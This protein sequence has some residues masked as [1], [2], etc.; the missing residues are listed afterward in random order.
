MPYRGFISRFTVI[1]TVVSMAT[2]LQ[3]AGLPDALAACRANASDAERLACYDRLADR[4]TGPDPAEVSM[5]PPDPVAPPAG[6]DADV[7]RTLSPEELFGLSAESIQQSLEE[8]SGNSP[9]SELSALVTEVKP[10]GPGRILVMLDN[11]QVWHQVSSPTLRLK[12]RDKVTIRKAAF[13]SY[14]MNKEG[15]SRTMRVRRK[16]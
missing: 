7:T 2:A 16:K 8:T 14:K 13:G 9:I 5:E 6:E 12:V 1:A 15:S 3:A 4:S 10:S 11:G